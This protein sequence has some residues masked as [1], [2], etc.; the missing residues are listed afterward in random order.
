MKLFF[1]NIVTFITVSLCVLTIDAQ[2]PAWSYFVS[3][4]STA[5]F[6]IVT[7]STIVIPENTLSG[8]AVPYINELDLREVDKTK[9]AGSIPYTTD[10]DHTGQVHVTVPLDSFTT[11]NESSHGISISYNNPNSFNM[12]GYGW[13]IQG[14]SSILRVNKNYFT[15]QNVEGI[16]CDTTD[17]WALDGQRLI[18]KGASATHRIYYTQ[19]GNI[20]VMQNKSTG[21]FVA[22]YP[23]GRVGLYTANDVFGY[24]ITRMAFIDG[25]EVNYQYQA[26]YGG[27]RKVP[28]S[29]TYGNDRQLIFNYERTDNQGTGGIDRNIYY[30]GYFIHYYSRLSSI[31]MKYGNKTIGSYKFAFFGPDVY[32]Q[33]RTIERVDSTGIS[34]LNPL[35]FYYFDQGGCMNNSS[36]G[37]D[38][39]FSQTRPDRFN[40][41]RGRFDNSI[42]DDGVYVYPNKLSY[43]RDGNK[44]INCYQDSDTMIVT[45]AVNKL[46]GVSQSCKVG[47]YQKFVDAF[48]I[49]VDQDGED[50]LLRINNDVSN[51]L[52][53]VRLNIMK[54]NQNL[55]MGWVTTYNIST[56]TVGQNSV[57]PKFFY[58]GDFDGD[59]KGELLIAYPSDPLG[60]TMDG[61]LKLIDPSTGLYKDDLTF[62]FYVDWVRK[63]DSEN[64]QRE[65]FSNSDQLVPIDYNGDGKLELAHISSAGTTIYGYRRNGNNLVFEQMSQSSFPSRSSLAAYY[66]HTGDF[67]GDGLADLL[68]TAKPQQY[69]DTLK[70][71][72]CYLGRGNGVFEYS[73]GLNLAPNDKKTQ[74]GTTY[75]LP[76]HYL[77]QDIDR[78]GITDVV[79]Y[80]WNQSGNLCLAFLRMENGRFDVSYSSN[81]YAPASQDMVMIPISLSGSCENVGMIAVIDSVF[82]KFAFSAPYNETRQL[83]GLTDGYGLSTLFSYDNLFGQS[84][85]YTVNHDRFTFPYATYSGVLTVCTGMKK[86]NGSN[87][88]NDITYSYRN[89]G[90]HKQGLGFCGF[91]QMTA[92]DEETGKTIENRFIPEQFGVPS[93]EE[94]DEQVKKYGFNISVNP[95]KRIQIHLMADTVQNKLTGSTYISSYAYDTY[96]NCLSK[97]TTTGDGWTVSNVNTYLN[98]TTTS[99]YAVG[100]PLSRVET[101]THN[102]L[103]AVKGMNITYNNTHLTESIT[104]WIGSATNVVK[105]QSFQYDNNSRNLVSSSVRNYQGAWLT[106]NYSYTGTSG[107]LLS[108][109]RNE[110]GNNTYYRYNEFGLREKRESKPWLDEVGVEP[111][112]SHDGDS[113]AIEIPFPLEYYGVLTSYKYDSFGR[114]F[115][116]SVL[117]E[118][119]DTTSIEWAENNDVNAIIKITTHTQNMPTQATYYDPLQRK[120]KEKVQHLDG[121]FLTTDY[122]YNNMGLLMRETMPYLTARTIFY[123]TYTYDDYARLLTRNHF[124][125][126]TDHYSYSGKTVTSIIDGIQ[127]SK[128]F[129]DMG[130]LVS[131][132]DPGGTILYDYRPDGNPSSITLNGTIATTFAYD[133]YGRRTSITDPSAG[134]KTCSYDAAGNMNLETDAC[135]RTVAYT[136]D[137]HGRVLTATCNGTIFTTTYDE[138]GNVSKIQGSNGATKEF[139]YDAYHRMTSLKIGN[140]E[141]YIFYLTK[142]LVSDVAYKLPSGYI[143]IE[144]YHYANGNLASI[145]FN[146]S[147]T[148]WSPVQESNYGGITIRGTAGCYDMRFT[149]D[150]HLRPT[151][152]RA[153]YNGNFVWDQECCYS[154]SD[155]NMEWRYDN[156]RDCY[157]GFEYDNLN[158][159]I[160]CNDVDIATYDS[161][162]NLITRPAEGRELGYGQTKPYAFNSMTF[163]TQPLN[164]RNQRLVFNGMQLPD[165]IFEN[166]HTAAFT[167]FGDRQRSRM[168]VDHGS[169]N[170]LTVDYFDMQYNKFTKIEGGLQSTKEVIF[171]GGTPYNA[172]AALLNDSTTQGGWKFCTI[173]RDNIGSICQVRDNSGNLLQE[174][175]Y[176]AWGQLRDPDTLVPYDDDN[177]PD[178]LLGRGYT[179]HEH[180]PWFGLINMNARLYE[181]SSGRFLS[182]DPMV[183]LP[184]FTQGFNRYSYCLNN[185][186]KYKDEDGNIFFLVPILVGAAIGSATAVLTE[187]FTSL[188]SYGKWH[189]SWK[190]FAVG[191]ISGAIGA[192]IGMLGNA[193]SSSLSNNFAFNL[194]GQVA[195]MATTNAIFNIDTDWSEILGAL[196]GAGVGMVFPRFKAIKAKPFINT[197]AEMG[198]NMLRGATTGSL[199]GLVTAFFKKDCSYFWK[200]MF[201]ST[202]SAG[203]RTFFMN[204]IFGAPF[205]VESDY[206]RPEGLY[207]TGG[208]GSVFFSRGNGITLGNNIFIAEK[209][210]KTINHEDWHIVQQLSL[211]W[212][213]FYMRI[214]YEMFK[215]GWY[216]HVY[217]VE[218]TLEYKAD[219]REK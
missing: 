5:Q 50:E 163:D 7:D 215:Y 180:L 89:A 14:L 48:A 1:K 25:R 185:P 160:S 13:N 52:D 125:S 82:T 218:G 10:V 201:G 168:V 76:Y 16:K 139:T 175:S 105:T 60:S 59:G 3:N 4:D 96:G 28:A 61:K 165:S 133:V 70:A 91:E 137:S 209:D 164:M 184:D 84:Q 169:G 147:I 80:G 120:V 73:G 17:V 167:Y 166:G 132:T 111:I 72:K 202:V 38:M 193:I 206:L 47:L 171:L 146:D 77:A 176:D 15:D 100:F 42:D 74:S 213:T 98:D 66:L 31:D 79:K 170:S 174:L 35:Q 71:A 195:N 99:G 141:K 210:I 157:E 158:R 129:D 37:A 115:T 64:K 30:C 155:G 55:E 148:I 81:Y 190:T 151:R 216:P 150:L 109:F 27:G 208:I 34:T 154:F 86:I 22:Y 75:V 214:I 204:V 53:I 124:F 117:E 118:S 138:D 57:R 217:E 149:H 128:T 219:H 122:Y 97:E 108:S 152:S 95:D 126:Q 196:A 123:K 102:G 88:Y 121:N 143:C 33:V 173:L 21:N 92:F 65:R 68:L 103:T 198:H 145:M 162:G 177:Q 134:T 85:C 19:N 94:T 78:D 130:N 56:N 58:A 200:E 101:T 18:L 20:K 49:D 90:I 203:S 156:I 12:L 144:N 106:C 24:Y 116:T 44:Y 178:L 112:E 212:A 135:N 36:C 39:Y 11:A 32:S 63:G 46:S 136:H 62:N 131:V 93:K 23:D 8:R 191:A 107:R 40:A 153:R 67:N 161:K 113:D 194:I 29:I 83:A 211:S 43:L 159:L 6:S 69:A 181:P 188:I 179:G 197:L 114:L 182:P 192:G 119:S 183:Q 142:N 26:G 199:H 186:F 110:F 205:P 140:Y 51:G 207:R 41:G 2:R 45:T 189:F 187:G 87:T 127:S 104:E 172:W 54:L 9:P